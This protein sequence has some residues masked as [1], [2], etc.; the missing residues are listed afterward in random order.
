MLL[1]TATPSLGQPTPVRGWQF[2]EEY[3]RK[4]TKVTPF[5]PTTVPAGKQLPPVPALYGSV[6]PE[7]AVCGVPGAAVYCGITVPCGRKELESLS[8]G[9]Q[10]PEAAILFSSRQVSAWP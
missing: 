3:C 4:P 1:K 6:R 2:G 8:N 5:A 7:Q 9:P 10:P